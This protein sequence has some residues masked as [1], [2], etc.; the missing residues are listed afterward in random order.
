MTAPQ[1]PSSRPIPIQTAAARPSA[2]D[3]ARQKAALLAQAEAT[4][5]RLQALMRAPHRLSFFL[6]MLLLVAGSLWWALVQTDRFSGALQLQQ[7][8]PATLVHAHVMVYGFMP[9]YF[10]GFLFTAGPKWLNVT[11]PTTQQVRPLLLM[12]ATGWLLWLVGAQLHQTLALLGGTLA[13]LGLCW[14][15]ALWWKLVRSSV[16]QDRLHAKSVGLGGLAGCVCLAAS[17]LALWQGDAASSRLWTLSGLWAFIVVTFVAV[18]HRMI[19][20][21]TSNAVPMVQVWR[22]FWVLGLMLGAAIFEAVVPWLEALGLRGQGWMLLRGVI[23]LGLAGMLL[24]LAV[25]W[26][27]VQSLKIRLLAMLHIGFIWLGLAFLISGLTNILGATSG[28]VLPWA[29]LHALTMGCLGSLILAMVTRVSC[30][31][32]GRALIADDKVWALFWLLQLAIVLRLAGAFPSAQAALLLMLSALLWTGIV[33][34]WAWRYSR[35]Y[36]KPRVDGKEG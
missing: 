11:A 34:V 30:G 12:Q 32:S 1:P 26:G 6:A 36:G 33:A 35:W 19:P 16:H 15:Y 20:F 5:W 14:M 18:A 24:W 2:E 13:L 28:L 8:L 10:A 27:L 22:P 3:K 23:E 29:A 31:H 9:L 25:V 7:T 21:F 4:P 17:L